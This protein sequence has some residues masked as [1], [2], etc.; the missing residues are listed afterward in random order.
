VGLFG[1]MKAAVGVGAADVS[2][3]LEK[4]SYHW[5]ETIRGRAVLKG[6]QVEQQVS[7]LKVVIVESWMER[8]RDMDGDTSRERR[9]RYYGQRVLA[10]QLSVAP[11]SQQQW[12]FE[13]Q[14]PGEGTLSH[15]WSVQASAG[16][17]GAVDRHSSCAFRLLPTAG[18]IGL[19][20]ALYQ[21]LPCTVN[22]MS[23]NST[24]VS[25]DF[26]P[27]ATHQQA[28]DGLMLIVQDDGNQVSGV[29]EVN[30]QEKSFSDRLKALTKQDRVKYPI[31]FPSAPLAAAADGSGPAPA[32]VTT[33]LRE[34]IQPHLS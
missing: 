22:S 25:V 5:N 14:L 27:P 19:V 6:G 16:V 26:K 18:V 4:G 9:Y 23:N 15:E 3:T 32:E 34:L 13:V 17:A 31:A 1:Q 8:T 28:L 20:N 11:D 24:Q 30:P 33:H 29:L 21:A 2:V 7:E 10:T 12:D